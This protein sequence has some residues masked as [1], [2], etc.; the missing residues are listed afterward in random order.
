MLISFC[1]RLERDIKLPRNDLAD[2]Q[3]N[4][5]HDIDHL[6]TPSLHQHLMTLAADKAVAFTRR[7]D[8]VLNS[9]VDHLPPDLSVKRRERLR[10]GATLLIA[11]TTAVLKEDLAVTQSWQQQLGAAKERVSMEP[12]IARCDGIGMIQFPCY[13]SF[14]LQ[15]A[16]VKNFNM[17]SISRQRKQFNTKTEST[18]I[19]L[20][21]RQRIVQR[22]VTGENPHDLFTTARVEDF[23]D[24]IELEGDPFVRSSLREALL[25]DL[26]AALHPAHGQSVGGVLPSSTISSSNFAVGPLSVHH[27]PNRLI[28][29]SLQNFSRSRSQTE[30]LNRAKPFEV[31]EVQ[32]TFTKLKIT[33]IATPTGARPQCQLES[34]PKY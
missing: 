5:F 12:L 3:S 16:E 17:V 8:T 33:G 24:E 27:T 14:S 20:A 9:L 30:G 32:S 26:T 31:D 21:L 19:A 34:S 22:D 7:N 6:S 10:S 1:Y 25:S 2:N 15:M 23:D 4:S 18:N 29:T 13:F 11:H 28:C